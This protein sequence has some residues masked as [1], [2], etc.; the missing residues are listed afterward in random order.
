MSQ[1][2]RIKRS[3]KKNKK[4]GRILHTS[5]EYYLPVFFGQE[6]IDLNKEFTARKE[7][8]AFDGCNNHADLLIFLDDLRSGTNEYAVTPVCLD[9]ESEFCIKHPAMVLGDD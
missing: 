4:L 7:P 6:G 8:C 3:T 2:R 1:L 5:R 9:H